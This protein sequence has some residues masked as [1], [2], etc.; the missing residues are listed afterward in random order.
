MLIDGRRL[1]F[2]KPDIAEASTIEES[3]NG[4]YIQATFF[5]GSDTPIC[6]LAS[7]SEVVQTKYM[8]SGSQGI[9]IQG[10]LDESARKTATHFLRGSDT[11]ELNNAHHT[12]RGGSLFVDSGGFAYVGERYE[13]FKRVILLAMLS[14][15]YILAL[16]KRVSALSE[17]IRKRPDR[18]KAIELHHNMLA[19]NAG[20]YPRLPV[21]LARHELSKVWDV[22][23]QSYRI[24]ELRDEHTN[25]LSAIALWLRDLQE[26]EHAR[27]RA[28]RAVAEA[29]A[30]EQQRQ[31]EAK[32][33]RRVNIYLTVL[34]IALALL[35]LAV[36]IMA[37]P[38]DVLKL[39]FGWIK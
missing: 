12:A 11:L 19:F 39:A 32:R 13:Q 9:F 25:Q 29:S 34:S 10:T 7:L 22:F 4:D 33:E 24:N 6:M 31:K 27:L 16:E 1:A 2:F 21:N 20:F 30:I 17:S 35:S 23:S 18:L 28:A 26:A 36:A 5:E 37:L 3:L 8:S 38:N 14:R 15:A